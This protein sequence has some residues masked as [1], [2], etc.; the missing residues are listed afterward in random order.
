MSKRKKEILGK[1]KSN[2]IRLNGSIMLRQNGKRYGGSYKSLSYLGLGVKREEFA[3]EKRRHLKGS[4]ERD[5]T[6]GTA[7]NT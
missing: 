1:S 4:G 2:V 3:A 6:M 5:I 7:H